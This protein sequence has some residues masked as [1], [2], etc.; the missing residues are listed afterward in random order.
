M[1]GPGNTELRNHVETWF[2]SLG[3]TLY[4]LLLSILGGVSWHLVCDLLL[5][6]DILSASLL[7]FY[8]MFTM[9]SVLNVI[10]GVFVDTAIQ[11]SNSQRDIQIEREMEL[12]DSFLKSL[13]DF[14]EA[15]D[16]D[17]SGSIHLEE[18]KIMLQ[19]PTLAAYFA[20]LGFDEV[21]ANQ[22]FHLLDDDESGE[23]SIEEFLEGCSKLKGAARSID[24]HALMHQ[25]RALHRELNFVASMLGVDMHSSTALA[26][27]HPYWNGRGSRHVGRATN[28]PPATSA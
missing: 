27:R 22:I 2:G 10:T 12:K 4:T 21:N 7:L 14:F 18:I 3:R 26:H 13:K 5:E 8:I 28:L 16:T 1:S 17:G 9:F 15:L 23:V 25:C 24:V 6:I 11:T 19:D 20:V